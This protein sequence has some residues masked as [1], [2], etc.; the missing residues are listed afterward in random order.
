MKLL[1]VTIPCY[2][3]QEYMEH[4]I[5]TALTGGEAIEILIVD[6]GSSDNTLSIAKEYEKK[7]PTI[8]RALHKENGGHGSA[9]N[10]GIQNANG[11]FF[12]VLDSDDW[13]DEA[14][15][16]K[17]LHFIQYLVKESIPLDLI[18]SN[19]VYEKP[20][21]HKRKVVN[22]RSAIPCNRF[23]TW[24]DVKH[25][26]MT[27]NLLMH[28]IMYRTQ[29]LKD[30][31]LTLPEHTFYVDNIFAYVPL[32][33]VRKMYYL[34]VDL[35]RYYIGMYDQ[36]VNET[37]MTRRIDQQI[38]ITKIMIDSHDLMT[39]SSK[40]LQSYMLQYLSMMMIVSSALLV[41]EGSAEN[42]AKRD[43]L[44]NYLKNSNKQVYRL[45][46][47]RKF[48]LPL[49]FKSSIG[50]KIIIHGYHFFNR[51]YGFN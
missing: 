40:K 47:E 43:E 29:L 41:N 22:Y 26:R 46:T 51:I 48:G 16:K 25:F 34:N 38:K 3:S 11:L 36:S 8:I 7:Y 13:F 50:K 35:Y 44:W 45:I 23:F 33:S 27:Q 12:K 21:I 10:T 2:N 28:S 39:I 5:Q 19:Y 37:V 30:C 32:P 24:D 18:I 1:T 17:I 6:D 49:Q 31:H 9:V 14:S 4:A 15:L 20:S 42:L